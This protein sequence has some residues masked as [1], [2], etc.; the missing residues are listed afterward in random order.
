MPTRCNNSSLL[1]QKKTLLRTSH[2]N[3]AGM[4]ILFFMNATLS[5]AIY[6]TL[7]FKSTNYNLFNS[8]LSVYIYKKN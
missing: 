7:H 3:I 5:Y 2:D 6:V 1:K 8:G 4:T